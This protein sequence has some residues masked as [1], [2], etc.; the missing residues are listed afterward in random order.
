MNQHDIK[1]EL[2]HYT[3]EADLRNVP[4]WL[5]DAIKSWIEAVE[6]NQD[7]YVYYNENKEKVSSRTDYLSLDQLLELDESYDKFR[8]WFNKQKA[9]FDR[10]KR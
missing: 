6:L 4:Q 5:K 8:D 10:A 9:R 2:I 1:Q 3:R 7:E